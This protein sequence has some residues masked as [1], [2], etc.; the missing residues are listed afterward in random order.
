M[1]VRFLNDSSAVR[2]S[3]TIIKGPVTGVPVAALKSGLHLAPVR[4]NPASGT[5]RVEYTLAAA[6]DARLSVHDV[7]G[8][9]VTTLARG[10]HTAGTHS[11]AWD[12]AIHTGQRAA[13]GVYYAVLEFG[14]ELRAVPIVR[15]E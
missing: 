14:G 1:E 13:P 8:R 7:S 6:G 11:A 5:V 3:F 15:V 2:D 10:P 9:R 12:G 4:P